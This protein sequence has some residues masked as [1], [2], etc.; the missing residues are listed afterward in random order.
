VFADARHF[1]NLDTSRVPSYLD[2]PA[3]LRSVGTRYTFPS[4]TLLALDAAV[5]H[6]RLPEKARERYD[7]YASLGSYVRQQLWRLG[8][9]PLAPDK[10]AAPVIT[11]FAPPEGESSEAFVARC[12]FWGYEL[13]GQSGYLAERRLVQIATMGAVTCELCAPLFTHLENALVP[14]PALATA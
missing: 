5:A 13:G 12:R 9:E 6:Y 2:L 8:L 14:K 10:C 1:A 3:A 11:T 4:P 7:H